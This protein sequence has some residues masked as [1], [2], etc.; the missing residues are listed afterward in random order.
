MPTSVPAASAPGDIERSVHRV[1]R[2]SGE[3][4]TVVTYAFDA[5][6]VRVQ[7][8][9]ATSL[10]DRAQQRRGSGVSVQAAAELPAVRKLMRHEMLLVNGGFSTSTTDRPAG[11][12]ISDGNAVTVP[13]YAMRRGDPDNACPA[14]RTGRLR[15]SALLCVRA[16]H[17]L[18]VG[19]M[20]DDAISRCEQAIQT[21]PVLLDKSGQ[22]EVCAS[23]DERAYL[24]TAICQRDARVH[25]VIATDPMTLHDLARWLAA[26]PAGGGL[27]CSA[28][29]N[30]SGD[31]STGALYSA[32]AGTKPR[33]D[34]PGG[35]AQASFL[36]VTPRTAPGG[37]G[38]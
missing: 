1:A 11:L 20:D 37:R 8:L 3:P 32:G 33:I 34:G 29:I 27:G 6:R 38:E 23:N 26:P 14:L 16:D 15:L 12:L 5:N 22:P 25:V 36:L 4:A 17:S 19:P 10:L 35:F 7:V 28:A 18:S 30:M 2:S 21:G 13:N 9:L 24:R 31:T